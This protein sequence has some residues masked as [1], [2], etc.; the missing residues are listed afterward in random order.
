MSGLPVGGRFLLR[1]LVRSA[2]S[3]RCRRANPSPTG[4]AKCCQMSAKIARVLTKAQHS[5]WDVNNVGT[6][7]AFPFYP[8]LWGRCRMR[9]LVGLVVCSLC[10]VGYGQDVPQAA[11]VPV[12][13]QPKVA[14]VAQQAVPAPQTVSPATTAGAWHRNS[15]GQ[16]CWYAGSQTP[17]TS[18]APMA[19]SQPYTAYRFSLDPNASQSQQVDALQRQVSTMRQAISDMQTLQ[20]DNRDDWFS[21]QQRGDGGSDPSLFQ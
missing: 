5:Q 19:N 20:K 13:L 2:A 17:A 6:D 7:A 1:T 14:K 9:F 10:A 16:W 8:V 12:K 3:G 21:R 18:A 4:R 15:S 11:R